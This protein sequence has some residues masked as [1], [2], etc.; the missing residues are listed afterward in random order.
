[1]VMTSPASPAIASSSNGIDRSAETADVLRRVIDQLTTNGKADVAFGTPQVVGDR[2]IIPVAR[3]TYGFGG[4]SGAENAPQVGSGAGGGLAVRPFAVVEVSQE[5]VRVVPIVDVQSMMGRVFGFA[6]AA[7]LVAA[8]ARRAR[9]QQPRSHVK[10]GRIE[11]HFSVTSTPT[12]YVQRR[13]SGGV[14][15]R[16][17]RLR[18]AEAKKRR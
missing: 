3:V 1:M 8:L 7:L 16:L 2:T 13:G 17:L 6:T 5:K 15:R 18:M 12:I 4:G 11:P 14:L 9:E 10:I